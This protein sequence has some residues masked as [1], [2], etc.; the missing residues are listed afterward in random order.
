M[1]VDFHLVC[2]RE[3]SAER[4]I[5]PQDRVDHTLSACA[6][7]RERGRVRAHIGENA[8]ERDARVVHW[9]HGHGRLAVRHARPDAARH[10]L[11]RKIQGQEFRHR[12][13]ALGDVLVDRNAAR[14]TA[15][16]AELTSNA[17]TGQ[18]L[19]AREHLGAGE[20]RADRGAVRVTARAIE[21]GLAVEALHDDQIILV[22]RAHEG[23]QNRAGRE[24][25]ARARRGPRRRDRAVRR[26]DDDQAFRK[27]GRAL[28]TG[29]MHVIQE[30]K[31]ERGSGGSA[32][33]HAARESNGHCPPP[34][35][36]W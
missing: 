35:S 15:R 27:C 5:T 18:E 33:Q 2:A 12:A 10:A 32:E 28:R 19:H 13:D 29:A 22:P 25:R 23:L 20:Q 6:L 4:R 34:C 11:D 17:A 26:E 3:R 31:R 8:I 16:A 36:E 9:C 24:R 30:R 1:R 7:K 14:P 21:R